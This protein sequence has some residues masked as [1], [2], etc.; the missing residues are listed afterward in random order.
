MTLVC[1]D[2]VGEDAAI[3]PATELVER[4][5]RRR[6]SGD[7]RRGRRSP[8]VSVS[9]GPASP[10]HVRAPS[11]DVIIEAVVEETVDGEERD[12]LGVSERPFM[13]RRK[14][15]SASAPSGQEPEH[16]ERPRVHRKNR[17][18]PLDRIPVSQSGGFDHILRLRS[19]PFVVSEPEN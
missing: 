11:P 7:K 10:G 2:R 19:F 5:A 18:A 9:P 13:F 1:R 6:D 17:K 14:T 8:R 16:A 15:I 12:A 4:P 3:S